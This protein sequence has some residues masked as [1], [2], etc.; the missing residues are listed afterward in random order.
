MLEVGREA[1][2]SSAVEDALA[3]LEQELL[4]EAMQDDSDIQSLQPHLLF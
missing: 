2:T 3:E 1:V 4:S